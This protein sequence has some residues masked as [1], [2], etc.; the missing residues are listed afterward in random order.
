MKKQH[1]AFF[2]LSK[3]ESR[4]ITTQTM[5]YMFLILMEIVYNSTTG[6]KWGTEDLIFTRTRWRRLYL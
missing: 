6:C 5:A 3:L 4:G 2:G 1:Q